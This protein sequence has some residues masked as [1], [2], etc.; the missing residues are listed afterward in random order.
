[1]K[2][3]LVHNYYGSSAPSG[4][5]L[6]FESERDL[7]LNRGVTVKLFTRHSDEIR[8]KGAWGVIKGACSVPWNPWAASDMARIL[9]SFKP[10]VVHIHNTFP[11]ISPSI[12]HSIGS[13][14]ARVFTLHNYRIFCPAGTPMRDGKVCIECL[15]SRTP[16][17]AFK[18]GCYRGSRLATLPL[19]CGIL[20]HNKLG[21]WNKHV[22][23]FITLS[24]FQRNLMIK[25][26]LPNGLV[27]VKP[28]FIAGNPQVVPWPDRGEPYVVFAGR[29]TFQKGLITLLRAWQTWGEHAP[30]LRLIGD[31]ELR[32]ELEIMAAGLNVRF[33]G[34][35]PREEVYCQISRAHLLVLPSESFETFGLVVA[36]AFAFGTPTAVS[37]IGPLPSIVKDGI[38]G[39]VFLPGNSE[40]LF[41]T[42]KSAWEKLGFLE[43]LGRGA[44]AVFEKKLN[45][46]VNFDKLMN[47]YALAIENV[48][49]NSRN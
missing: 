17:P 38:S 9:E 31:G 3:L 23:A 33:F 40:N 10:D 26:G 11:M 42:I 21:T 25:S 15:E 47:I 43:R 32:S 8:S 4:E 2:V 19:A 45:E 14:A 44:R 28:N 12:F 6:A 37:N 34:Q 46:E 29:L 48:K 5:N 24:D 18:Y 49:F 27:H 20:L 1:M 41:S 16:A 13:R 35:L 7:L 39:I 30:E 36:E 22:D